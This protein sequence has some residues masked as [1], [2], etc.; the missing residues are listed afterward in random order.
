MTLLQWLALPYMRRE[1][2][3]WGRAFNSLVGGYQSDEQ[4]KDEPRR[5]IRGR[6]HGYEMELDLSRWSERLTYFLGRFYDLPTQLAMIEI[7]RPG[8]RFVDVGANIGMLTLL[9]SRL[10]GP[11]GSVDSFEPNPRNLERIA[12]FLAANHIEN[13]R[14]HPAA[15]GEVPGKLP[16]SVPRNNSGE[17]TLTPM[18]GIEANG[19]DRFQTF[20]V[21]VLVG[22]QVLAAH[23][24]PPAL[25]KID[26]EGFELHVLS[27][28]RQ[29]L[30]SARP[31]VTTEMKPEHLVRAGHTTNHL[32]ELMG[33]HGYQAFRLE[34]S[35]RGTSPK[36]DL[37]PAG[38]TDA[39]YD[40][41]WIH[42]DG[43]VSSRLTSL[44]GKSRA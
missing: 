18:A 21:D 37:R 25:I 11:T 14:V 22:D 39:D 5:T 7:L 12:G 3:G 9:G 26:V 1:L 30:A 43:P 44:I 40:A 38:A 28:L 24:A 34:T 16:L 33:S 2:P 8:D 19:L 31:V 17:G 20:E 10:V 27:G 29:T 35:G 6:L 15:L 13:V 41:I 36:L 23:D 32:F 4:W 42:P